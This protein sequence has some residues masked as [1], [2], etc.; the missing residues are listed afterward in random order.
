[1]SDIVIALREY[2]WFQKN[3]VSCVKVA[4]GQGFNERDTQNIQ[5]HTVSSTI[6]CYGYVKTKK[7]YFI[8]A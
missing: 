7:K 8:L 4:R 5:S 3:Q 6:K 1:M 2:F